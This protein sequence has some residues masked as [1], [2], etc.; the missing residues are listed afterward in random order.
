MWRYLIAPG[1]P[2]VTAVTSNRIL[3][4]TRSQTQTAKKADSDTR[5]G[6]QAAA[7]RRASRLSQAWSGPHP[8]SAVDAATTRSVSHG[9]QAKKGIFDSWRALLEV[10]SFPSLSLPPVLSSLSSIFGTLASSDVALD[11]TR[12]FATAV[13]C[14]SSVGNPSLAL[15]LQCLKV[16]PVGVRRVAH[17]TDT[18]RQPRNIKKIVASAHAAHAP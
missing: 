11:S 16:H 8:D 5:S 17:H 14:R 15:S 1:R 12:K 4:P 2:P 3:I 7:H 6:I 13:A 9:E 10:S 18:F